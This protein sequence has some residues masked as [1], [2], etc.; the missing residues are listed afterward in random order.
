[1]VVRARGGVER[2]LRETFELQLHTPGSRRPFT[3]MGLQTFST[4]SSRLPH[5]RL[6]RETFEPQLLT[7]GSQLP[8]A[9]PTTTVVEVGP[10]AAF[11]TAFSTNAVSIC[12]SVGLTQV[13]I[14]FSC[15][16]AVGV[17]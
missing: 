10:R 14:N 6:L 7:P 1:M 4:S 11:A 2:L 9:G 16:L 5:D 3:F 13:C 12:S 8:A 17:L 15:V